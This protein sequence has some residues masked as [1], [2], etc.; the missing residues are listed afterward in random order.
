MRKNE[1]KIIWQ[2]R[3]I[4]FS[5]VDHN[6]QYNNQYVYYTSTTAESME[7]NAL[8]VEENEEKTTGIYRYNI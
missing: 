2:A 8:N 1:G 4:F 6:E 5:I 7:E 3:K